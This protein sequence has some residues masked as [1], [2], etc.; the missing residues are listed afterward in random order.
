MTYEVTATNVEARPTAV[1]AARTTWREFPTLWPTLLDEVWACLRSGGVE[2]GCRN[3]MLYRD[4]AAPGDVDV[5]VGVVLDRPL[6]LT[7][8]VVM[9]TLPAGRSAM[10][11]HYGPYAGL[12]WAYDAVHDWCAA[13]GLPVAGPRWEVG[14][15]WVATG[16]DDAP[17]GYLIADVVD[18]C[19]HV[20]QVSV[21][22]RC[23]RRGVGFARSATARRPM[24]WIDGPAC[25]CA[26]TCR[27]EARNLS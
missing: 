13:Q 7:G 22:P 15:A 11:V 21:H 10:T 19:L 16:P 3:V 9:P 20:E 1:V 18:G 14:R 4:G 26:G 24:A 12:S 17:V 5:E 6:P 2:R 25:A 8:N 23:A 27:R